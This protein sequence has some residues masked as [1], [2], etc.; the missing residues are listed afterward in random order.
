MSASPKIDE[1][2]AILAIARYACG[3]KSSEEL[4][5]GITQAI[6]GESLEPKDTSP[7]EDFSQLQVVPIPAT[8]EEE[9]IITDA[10]AFPD[11][12]VQTATNAIPFTWMVGTIKSLRQSEMLPHRWGWSPPISWRRPA[13][14]QQCLNQRPAVESK[15]EKTIVALRWLCWACLWFC[16]SARHSLYML[17]HPTVQ[18]TMP[19]Q[20][21]AQVNGALPPSICSLSWLSHDCETEVCG[22]D[23]DC[24][25]FDS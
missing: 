12:R 22:F 6:D 8:D 5:A 18:Q 25:C 3:S 20:Q 13:F 23:G 2:R 10:Y 11:G 1:K 21:R 7:S 15:E 9:Q 4:G 19:L 14:L 24:E 16:W 17:V